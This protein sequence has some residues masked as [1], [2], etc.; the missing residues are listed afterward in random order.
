[1]NPAY[2]TSVFEVKGELPQSFLI[3]TA[4]NPKGLNAPLSRNLHQDATLKSVLV[5]RGLAPVRVIGQSPDGHHQEPG[6][7]VEL[8]LA[9]GLEVARIFKQLAI[10]VVESNQLSLHDCYGTK[11]VELGDWESKVI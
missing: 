7:A 9:T 11:K 6:W 1:M 3:I 10:Y 2:E 8:D 4:Y 5:N